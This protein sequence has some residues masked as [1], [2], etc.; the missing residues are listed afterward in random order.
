MAETISYPKPDRSNFTSDDPDEAELG[1]YEGILADGR[2][3]RAEIWWWEGIAGVT[4]I[5][6]TKGLESAT[7]GQILALLE[8]SGETRKFTK[9][10]L[11][12]PGG[13]LESRDAQGEPMWNLSLNLGLLSRAIVSGEVIFMPE[14]DAQI[15][16]PF[17][18]IISANVR[19]E[20]SFEKVLGE[21][22]S[23]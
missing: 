20:T 15:F 12:D 22:R 16:E 14:D 13:P 18:E 4:Y 3:F 2:P 10:A 19:Y 21:A 6:S 1:H 9:G 7:N 11:A 23:E 17:R 5:F 8:R